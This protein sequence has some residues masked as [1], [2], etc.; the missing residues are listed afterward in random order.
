MVFSKLMNSIDQ[1]KGGKVMIQGQLSYIIITLPGMTSYDK[2][3][4]Y[5]CRNEKLPGQEEQSHEERHPLSQYHD[6]KVLPQASMNSHF[7]P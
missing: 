6:K 3:I 5:V 1:R 7:Q 4:Y 2:C